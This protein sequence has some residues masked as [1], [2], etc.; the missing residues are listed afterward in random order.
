MVVWSIDWQSPSSLQ[1]SFQQ[2][3]EIHRLSEL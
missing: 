3:G 1:T 2:S